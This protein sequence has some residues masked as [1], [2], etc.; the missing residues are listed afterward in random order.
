MRRGWGAGEQTDRKWEACRPPER[1]LTS[2]SSG[3]SQRQPEPAA[4][5]QPAL[6]F[7]PSLS[8]DLGV[9]QAKLVFQ[10]WGKNRPAGKVGCNCLWRSPRHPP[11]RIEHSGEQGYILRVLCL[12]SG[13]NLSYNRPIQNSLLIFFPE[14]S[15]PQRSK[16]RRAKMP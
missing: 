13:M 11:K 7:S 10:L 9:W 12:C 3:V 16:G 8:P 6:V 15:Q 4:K 14:I 5:S 1:K 2:G